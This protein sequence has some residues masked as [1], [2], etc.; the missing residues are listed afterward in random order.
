MGS[1]GASRGDRTR[2]VTP[3]VP[4]PPETALHLCL[5]IRTNSRRREYTS[6]GGTAAVHTGRAGV[7]VPGV[8]ADPTTWR[9]RLSAGTVVVCATDRRRTG[10]VLRATRLDLV[11]AGST[12]FRRPVREHLPG[13]SAGRERAGGRAESLPPDGRPERGCSQAASRRRVRS[14][15]SSRDGG[16]SRVPALSCPGVEHGGT[17]TAT[18]VAASP[19]AVSVSSHRSATLLAPRRG[20]RMVRRTRSLLQLTG[21]HS[22]IRSA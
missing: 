11:A 21:T 4:P 10:S 17:P 15:A 9:D 7:L 18:L 12:S 20:W 5:Q 16:M 22:R 2:S 14:P 19:L 13:G 6:D 3:H 8:T 1:V